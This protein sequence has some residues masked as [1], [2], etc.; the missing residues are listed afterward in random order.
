MI[1][2]SGLHFIAELMKKPNKMLEIEK[3][4]LTLFYLKTDGQT[5]RMK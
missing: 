5:K 4:L 3:K 1:P 2:D